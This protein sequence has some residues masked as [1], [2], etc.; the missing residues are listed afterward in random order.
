MH[1]LTQYN[2]RRIYASNFDNQQSVY[3]PEITAIRDVR[4][5]DELDKVLQNQEALSR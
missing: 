3:H 5:Q 1:T 4:N 2:Q